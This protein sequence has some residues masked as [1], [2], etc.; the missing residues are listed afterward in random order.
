M[1]LSM[2]VAYLLAKTRETDRQTDREREI[3]AG[4]KMFFAD[5]R[6]HEEHLQ[7]IYLFVFLNLFT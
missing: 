4:P 7:S 5:A 3:C 1:T 2:R 6:K